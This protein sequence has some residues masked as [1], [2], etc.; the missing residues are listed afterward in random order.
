M[1][2]V[3]W[4][5]RDSHRCSTVCPLRGASDTSSKKANV[6]LWVKLPLWRTVSIQVF[7]SFS[8]RGVSLRLWYPPG[9]IYVSPCTTG[10]CIPSS[11]WNAA[12]SSKAI[13][14]EGDL[15][16]SSPVEHGC[17]DNAQ[18]FW[19]EGVWIFCDHFPLPFWEGW[20][21]GSI[22]LG[23]RITGLKVLPPRNMW[24]SLT[25]SHRMPKT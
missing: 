8:C 18:A 11:I 4:L 10:V 20:D 21:Q 22:C 19:L 14:G 16:F 2:S 13:T 6:T 3:Y 15:A 17:L 24:S 7:K 1:K 25:Q 12:P 5:Y 9:S 23:I